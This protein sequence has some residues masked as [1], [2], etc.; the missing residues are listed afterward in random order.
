M[1]ALATPAQLAA[2]MQTT[3]SDTDTSALLILQIASGMVQDA[4]QQNISAVNNDAI[5][6][7][8]IDGAYA[9][10]PEL[11]VTAVTLVE[12]SSDNGA[13]WTTVP[14]TNYTVSLKQGIVSAVPN[15]STSYPSTPGSWRITYSHGFATVPDAILGVV[16]GVAART[17][18][19]PAGVDSERIGGYQVKYQMLA[20]GLSPIEK[21]SLNRYVVPRIS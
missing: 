1:T 3:I 19:A 18:S 5:L 13:T 6:V 7:D 8:P 10:L 15:C 4:I 16:L 9:L 21:S 14:A 2:Y 12:I 20:D 11:P 17:Y